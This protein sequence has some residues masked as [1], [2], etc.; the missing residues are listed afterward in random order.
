M[1]I[2]KKSL[3]I[4]LII[5]VALCMSGFLGAERSYADTETGEGAIWFD[6]SN[7]T[8]ELGETETVKVYYTN[9]GHL[10]CSAPA[11]NVIQAEW[12]DYIDDEYGEY[13]EDYDYEYINIRGTAVGESTLTVFD[14]DDLNVSASLP[15]TV[16]DSWADDDDDDWDDDDDDDY[17]NERDQF[18]LELYSEFKDLYYGKTYLSG[19]SMEGAK[20]TL[21]YGGKTYKKTVGSTCKFKFKNLP[22]RK[23]GTRFTLTFKYN[24][25]TTK[26]TGKIK[27]NNPY[28]FNYW[29]YKNQT[30]FKGYATDVH[31]GDKI[32]VTIGN[33]SYTKKFTKSGKK[34]KYT[35]K[36]GKKSYGKKVKIKL[37]NKYGQTLTSY[38]DVVYY[39]KA[40]KVGMTMKQAKCVPGWTNP[41][42][43]HY[44]TYGTY[45]WYDDDGDGYA[46][47]SYLYFGS[48]GRLKSWYFQG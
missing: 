23:I 2:A 11:N 16:V 6:I 48:N 45:W 46:S 40:V 32:K 42:D 10:N 9:V 17:D 24:N 26:L 29:F 41:K 35:L 47:D 12:D 15:I 37:I 31:K 22:I 44:Y 7:L 36:V 27:N 39:A 43:K 20:V 5:A 33:K 14:D 4:L 3:S 8:V 28:V 21:K 25:V 38:S 1:T 34:I 18:R 13:D 30:K 19:E